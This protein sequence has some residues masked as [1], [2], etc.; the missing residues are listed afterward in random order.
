[1]V[2][3]SNDGGDDYGGDGDVMNF[4]D[5]VSQDGGVGEMCDAMND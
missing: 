1:M 3:D 2:N 4:N 5:S